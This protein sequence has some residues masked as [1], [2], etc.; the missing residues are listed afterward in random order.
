MIL[1]AHF[2]RIDCAFC[3]FGIDTETGTRGRIAVVAVVARFRDLPGAEV[4]SASLEAAGIVNCVF[5]GYTLGLVWTYSTALGGIRLHVSEAD[6]EE[7]HRLLEEAEVEW[8]AE[9]MDGHAD[10][11]CSVC[12]SDDLWVD[13]G[14]RK[15]LALMITTLFVPLWFWRSK[16]RCRSC[17]HAR[18]VALRFRPELIMVWIVA[19]LGVSVATVVIFLLVGFVIRGRA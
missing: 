18:L 10:E 6:V 4:A 5:D 7:A 16:L 1:I 3:F 11:S 17:G 8:P 14:P 9:V 19:G 13:S 15:T 2:A 12:G